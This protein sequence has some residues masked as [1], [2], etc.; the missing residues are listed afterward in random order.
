MMESN[1]TSL[2]GA[3]TAVAGPGSASAG[4]TFVSFVIADQLFGIPVTQVQDV[5]A[6]CDI[7]PVPLAPPEVAGSLNLRGRIVTAIEV[8][9]RLGLEP[10][11][12]DAP[13]MNIVVEHAHELYS[14]IVDSVGE[15]LNL[16]AADKERNPATLEPEFAEFSRGIYRLENRLLVELDAAALL[17]LETQ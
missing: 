16:P 10:R 8:R 11:Q 17:R 7:T 6:R 1:T 14:L 5:L 9:R 2:G 4:H 15:V 12:A 13:W 3:A